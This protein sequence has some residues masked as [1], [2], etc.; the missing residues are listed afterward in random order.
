MGRNVNWLG[1]KN[2]K[3]KEGR[4]LQIWKCALQKMRDAFDYT[5]K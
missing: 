3:K 5:L 4:C 2:Q 1:K